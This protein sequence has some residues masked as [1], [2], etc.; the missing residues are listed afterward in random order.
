M[1]IS[2][3]MADVKSKFCLVFGHKIFFKNHKMNIHKNSK[4]NIRDYRELI[5]LSL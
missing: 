1:N 2:D 3:V 5:S 4:S